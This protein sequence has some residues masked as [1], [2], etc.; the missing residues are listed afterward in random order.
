MIVF[1]ILHGLSIN[2][3]IKLTTYIYHPIRQILYR[4]FPQKRILW[5]NHLEI[6]VIEAVTLLLK[7]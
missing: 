4:T 5:N 1:I 3:F 2:I 7:T 6:G